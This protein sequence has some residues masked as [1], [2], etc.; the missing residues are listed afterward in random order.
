MKGYLIERRSSCILALDIL[1]QKKSIVYEDEMEKAKLRAKIDL[2]NDA[3]GFDENRKVT[4]KT[5]RVEYVDFV[6]ARSEVDAVDVFLQ[7]IDFLDSG[8]EAIDVYEVDN[9]HNAVKKRGE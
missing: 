1:R 8:N 9:H 7:N 6:D 4:N 3:L 2:V 5:Y